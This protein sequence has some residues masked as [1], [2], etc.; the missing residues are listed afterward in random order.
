MKNSI[1]FAGFADD[2][3]DWHIAKHDVYGEKFLESWADCT[4][5]QVD[6][7]ELELVGRLDNIAI[8]DEEEDTIKK[9]V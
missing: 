3:K 8:D 5:D 6:P 9:H 4:C 1:E 7:V 2:T